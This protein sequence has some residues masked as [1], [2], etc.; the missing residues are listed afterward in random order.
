[1]GGGGAGTGSRDFVHF[2][3]LSVYIRFGFDEFDQAT[4]VLEMKM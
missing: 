3:M 1:M 2:Y 4:F